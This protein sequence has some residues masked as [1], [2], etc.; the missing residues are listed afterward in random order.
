MSV[1]ICVDRR[2]GVHRDV[3]VRRCACVVQMGKSEKISLAVVCAYVMRAVS[4]S[5][6]K[7]V[8]DTKTI[9]VWYEGGRRN[10]DVF[11]GY[12]KMGSVE[13]AVYYNDYHSLTVVWQLLN[14]C[15][16]DVTYSIERVIGYWQ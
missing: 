3:W 15:R 7:C 6:T 5:G 13:Y 4:T 9:V 12:D 11:T 8:E 10:S 14:R 16:D 1:P 2:V